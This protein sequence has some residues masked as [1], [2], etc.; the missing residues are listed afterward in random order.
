VVGAVLSRMGHEAGD[1]REASAS[2]LPLGLPVERLARW[3][4]HEAE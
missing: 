3:F 4:W 2:V 1:G